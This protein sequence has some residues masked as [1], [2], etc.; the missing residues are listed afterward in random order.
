MLTADKKWKLFNQDLQKL[1]KANNLFGMGTI[2]YEMAAFLKTEG[3]D[4]N[5]LRKLGYEMKLRVQTEHLMDCKQSDVVTGVE[6]IAYPPTSCGACMRLHGKVFSM[7]EAMSIKPLPVEN[8]AYESGC[9]CCY[10]PK[11]D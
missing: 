1:M 6:I 4:D 8:C 2:Y 10:G 7:D 5:K 9:R 11:V 3:K